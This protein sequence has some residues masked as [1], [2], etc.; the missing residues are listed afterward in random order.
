MPS[1]GATNSDAGRSQPTA[2]SKKAL[3]CSSIMA[4]AQVSPLP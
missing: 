3:L 2:S 4:T 1:G